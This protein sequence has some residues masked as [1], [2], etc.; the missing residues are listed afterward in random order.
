MNQNT[1]ITTADP[2]YVAVDISKDSLQ[3]HTSGGKTCRITYDNTGLRALLKSI[4]SLPGPLVVCEATGGYERPLLDTLHKAGIPVNLINP[5]RLRAF[6]L[7]EAIKAKTDPIDALMILRFAQQKHLRP[8]PP[9]EPVRQELAALL[10]RRSHLTGELAR[11]KNR[12]GKCPK[13]I[14][15]SI[16]RMIRFVEKEIA[17]LDAQ[18]KLL[19]TSDRRLN[20]QSQL[21]QSVKGVGEVTAWTLLAYLAE[22]STLRR[23]QLV[24][25]AG[26]APFNRDSGKASAR[27]SIHAGR[28]KVRKC[29][30]MATHTAAR[31]NPVI[32]PYVAGLIAR[33]KPYKCAIVA[34]MRKLLIHL[35]SLLK[36]QNPLAL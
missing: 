3:V 31:H 32:K 30:Y 10:D 27:R 14:A 20:A 6:A 22:M 36:Q 25:L 4:R 23:N 1:S 13:A 8:T 19:V 17:S 35:H 7:S 28:S 2:H 33:G 21:F 24:A 16:R 11:E 9:P 26:V 15:T 12:L 34:A 5:S 18:V 29:L